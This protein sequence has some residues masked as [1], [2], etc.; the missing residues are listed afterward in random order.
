M[1]DLNRSA[2]IVEKI[3]KSVK[4]TDAGCFIWAGPTS[5]SV[6]RGKGYPRMK[7]DGQTVAVHRVMFVC[8]YGY[9]PGKKQIDHKCRNRLCV[10]PI[11]LQM[12]THKQNCKLRDEAKNESL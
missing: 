8:T 12:V 6:G 11:H 5:G 9:V 1:T 7:L 10:N 3:M 2:R 4:T